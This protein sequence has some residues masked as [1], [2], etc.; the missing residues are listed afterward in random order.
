MKIVEDKITIDELK[1]MSKKMFGGLVKVVVDVEREIIVVG[2]ELHS[3]EQG[4][5]IE[6]GSKY[7]N[8]WGINIYPEMFGQDNWIEFDSMIN[9]KPL[10][11]CRTRGVE[12]KQIQEK[13]I[14]IIN[15]FVKV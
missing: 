1:E 8:T 12:N 5:L 9:L 15:K 3:D 13:I 6:S 2:G 4:V 7:E 10:L 14:Q 11:D